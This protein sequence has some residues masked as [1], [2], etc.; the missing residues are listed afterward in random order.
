VTAYRVETERLVVRSWDPRDAQLLKTAV[1]ASLDHLT[2][3]P[4]RRFEPQTL[5]EKVELL[6]QMR[7]KF[8]LGQDFSFGIFDARES[9]VLGGIGL[10]PRGGIGAQAREIGYWINV[11]HIGRGYATEA[12]A[13]LVRVGFTIEKVKRIEIHTGPANVRSQAVARKLGFTLEATLRARAEDSKGNPRDTMI[14]SLFA[15]GYA[16]SPSA[17]RALRAFDA[18]GRAIA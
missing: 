11:A 9:E 7:G 6:R 4:W 12:A 14:W 1:D 8:D 3:M 5:D 16:A 2:E 17:A 15:D 13:A 18:A 10:H